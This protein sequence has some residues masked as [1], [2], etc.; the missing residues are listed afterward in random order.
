MEVGKEA[1]ASV[2]LPISISVCFCKRRPALSQ[3]IKNTTWQF[4]AAISWC[5]LC[6]VHWLLPPPQI[7]V[8]GKKELLAV[9]PNEQNIRETF[10]TSKYYRAW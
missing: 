8:Y 6:R 1:Q 2:L 4:L 7:T 5:S 3:G 9:F 10:L